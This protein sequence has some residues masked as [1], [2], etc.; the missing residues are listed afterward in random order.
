MI[1]FE[2]YINGKKVTTA[3]VE[4]GVMSVIANWV[5]SKRDGDLWNSSVS[6]AGLDDEAS[7]HLRWFRQDLVVGDEVQIRLVES[8]QIDSPT[9]REPK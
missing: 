5:R 3:G 1:A 9:E 8:K 6:I 2:L 4:R 7:E